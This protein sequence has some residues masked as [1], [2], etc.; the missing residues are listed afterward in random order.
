VGFFLGPVGDLAHILTHTTGYA[1]DIAKYYLGPL[2]IWVPFIFGGAT[3]AVGLSHPWFD[4]L[5][6]PSHPRPGQKSWARV[7]IGLAAF[8]SL[9]FF[10]GWMPWGPGITDVIIALLALLIWA[11]AD[12]TWQGLVLGILTAEIG[13]VV[14][15]S[16]VQMGGFYYYP[17]NNNLWGIPSWL[18]WLYLAASVTVGNLGR[19]L[20]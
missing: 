16:L 18:P 9:Y 13:T 2:P 5:L 6:G 8:L 14:E 1:P 11:L 15:L 10:S 3:L 7:W 17:P 12:W 20:S 4:N 19:K